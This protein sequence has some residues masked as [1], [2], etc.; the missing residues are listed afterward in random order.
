MSKLLLK[1]SD[2]K[3][4]IK[5]IISEEMNGLLE[6]K[7]SF[8]DPNKFDP[9]GNPIGKGGRSSDR[10]EYDMEKARQSMPGKEHIKSIISWDEV[11]GALTHGGFDLASKATNMGGGDLEMSK[12]HVI[13]LIQN[14]KI[15][16]GSKKKMILGFSKAR[17]VLGFL[18][19]A[20]NF[21]N[22][23]E[24]P[25]HKMSTTGITM[26]PRKRK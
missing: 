11:M 3:K 5:K 17:D 13:D 18:N 2:L 24:K 26:Q 12:A 6:R 4:Y 22:A 7:K 10:K 21:K 1:E 16:P 8:K 14:S 23:M 19:T 15:D 25:G 20:T 9:Q